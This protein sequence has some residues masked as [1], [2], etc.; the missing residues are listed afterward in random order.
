MGQS[1]IVRRAA[2]GRNVTM[3]YVTVAAPVAENDEPSPVSLFE[4]P[5]SGFVCLGVVQEGPY[6]VGHPAMIDALEHEVGARQGTYVEFGGTEVQVGYEYPR[7][8]SLPHLCL[9]RHG[10]RLLC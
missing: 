9:Y 1:Q 10:P 2:F 4:S 7:L 6:F 3:T 5:R 8:V